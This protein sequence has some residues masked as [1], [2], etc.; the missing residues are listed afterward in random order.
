M[1]HVTS[2]IACWDKGEMQIGEELVESPKTVVFAKVRNHAQN[3]E[4]VLIELGGCWYS[5]IGR[6]LKLAIDNALNCDFD[7]ASGFYR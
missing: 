6:E 5:F 3:S 7:S 1:I 2:E 4:A